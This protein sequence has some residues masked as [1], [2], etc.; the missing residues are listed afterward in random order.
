MHHTMFI[1]VVLETFV[2]LRGARDSKV[3][4]SCLVYGVNFR[5]KGTII[6]LKGDNWL[7][8]WLIAW[9]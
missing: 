7:F 9:V 5:W 4:N 8:G 1:F 3:L 2:V 6:N